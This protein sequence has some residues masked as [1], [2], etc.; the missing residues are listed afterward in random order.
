MVSGCGSVKGTCLLVSTRTIFDMGKGCIDTNKVKE[1]VVEGK[2][3][4]T[5][6]TT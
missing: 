1:G 2:E 5:T 4:G 3:G 6:R